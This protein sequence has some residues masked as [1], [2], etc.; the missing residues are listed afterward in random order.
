MRILLICLASHFRSNIWRQVC[1]SNTGRRPKGKR[2]GAAEGFQFEANTASYN[3]LE[4]SLG[5]IRFTWSPTPASAVPFRGAMTRCSPI[6]PSINHMYQ[7]IKVDVNFRTSFILHPGVDRHAE[8][9]HGSEVELCQIELLPDCAGASP[10]SPLEPT[11]A[12][13]P[14]RRAPRTLT[15]G[16]GLGMNVKGRDG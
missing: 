2:T 8:S 7:A 11:S 4:F 16:I 5:S 12:A 14:M 10:H 1:L 15:T 9:R 6:T 13:S 3:R